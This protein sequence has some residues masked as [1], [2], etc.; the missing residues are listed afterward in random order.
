MTKL[1]LRALPRLATAKGR[2]GDGDG[3]FLRVADADHRFWTY[4]YRLGGK[5]TELSLGPYPKIGLDEARRLHAK[6]RADVL[7]GA[8][9]RAAKK[10]GAKAKAAKADQTLPSVKPT[11]GAMADL[12]IET[13]E[14]S[15]RNPKHR[16][17]WI[18]S[19]RHYCGPI[20][21]IPVDRID[22]QAVLGCLKP[23][24]TKKPETASRV[25]GRI[26]IVLNAARALGH[27][28]LDKMNPAAWR[29][30]LDQLLP[31]RPSL[32]R[33]HHA[34]LDYR[35]VAAFVA[36]LREMGGLSALALE[37]L[38]LTCTRTNETMGARWQ[39]VDEAAATWTIP[40]GR[41]KIGKEHVV[42]LSDRA[43]AVLQ[44]A[45]RQAKRA[46]DAES[47]IFPGQ[48]PRRP[49]S[50][51]TFL[52]LLRR[53]NIEVTAHGFRS[54]ARTWMGER[55]VEFEVAE[56]CL[57]HTVGSAVVQA[58]MRSSL[59]E[60]RRPVLQAWADFIGKPGGDGADIISL[61]SR[62]G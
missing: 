60:R 36:R 53:M 50:N 56:A 52:M 10:L 13:H 22:T 5:E 25:R 9:P 57:G 45:R 35:E 12:Y 31:K 28:P 27:T 21:N 43:I 24:W 32:P 19:L 7:S 59:I 17:Q 40:A 16:S 54:S 8:D 30:H 48:R 3:L 26:E 11:F 55:G 33:G 42:P 39:E 62:R 23:I 49:L 1:T 4:R 15:W 58:D 6:A 41:A 2:H 44:E 18:S 61:A 38:I 46:P 29:G 51:M 37:F 14:S 47:F 20:R 34:A